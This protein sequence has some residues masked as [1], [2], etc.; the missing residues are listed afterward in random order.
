MPAHKLSQKS[1]V[2]G[3]YDRTAQNQESISGAGVV[4]RGL[5]Y[6]KNVLSSDKGELRK[7]LGTKK[8]VEL[9]AATVLIPYRQPN[10]NDAFLVVT[11]NEDIIGYELVD[12][13]PQ[14]LQTVV[15][16]SVSFPTRSD[17]QG[18]TSSGE[19][20]TYGDWVVTTSIRHYTGD[21]Y[22]YP[23]GQYVSKNLLGT[24]GH[25]CI[26]KDLT[27]GQYI[28][29]ENPINLG[30]L[31]ELKI[32]F[33]T[34]SSSTYSMEYW[35]NLVISYSDDGITW[36]GLNTQMIVGNV[37]TSTR[38]IHYPAALGGDVTMYCSQVTNTVKQTEYDVKHRYWR[39]TF[40]GG[41]LVNNK[42]YEMALFDVDWFNP[43]SVTDFHTTNPYSE[44]D[45][46][47]IKYA[48]DKNKLFIACAGK[49]PILIDSNAGQITATNFTPSN[50]PTLWTLTG[51]YPAAVALSQNRLW[52]GGFENKKT[53]VFASNFG[54]YDTFSENSPL[55]YTDMLNLTCNQLKSGI[56]NIVGGQNV[57]YC[58][59]QDGISMI[60]GGSNG[61]IPTNQSIEFQLRN[62]MPAGDAT[63][64]FKDDIMLY[65]SSDGTKLYGV[66][67]DLLVN[68]F[69]VSDL[70]MYAKDI[71]YNKITELHYVNNESKLVY[72]LTEN[73]K[74]FSLLFEKGNYQGFFPLDFNGEVY[75]ICP[76]KVGRD[77]KLLMVVFRDGR[78]Y[79]EE[80]LDCGH[81]I[82]TST[83][84]LTADEKKWA[85]YDNLENNIALDCYQTYDEGIATLSTV[86][87]NST[88]ATD[89]D[90]S[91]YI[92]KTVMF[93]NTSNKDWDIYTINSVNSLSLWTGN[94]D[95]TGVKYYTL[96]S[97]PVADDDLLDANGNPIQLDDLT[98]SKKI[99][100]AH[101][102][103]DMYGTRI[104]IETRLKA[105]PDTG[106]VSFAYIQT[107]VERY[108]M[109][110]TFEAKRG[111]STSFT[112][113]YPEFTKFQPNLPPTSSIAVISEGRYFDAQTPDSDGYINLPAVCH[114]VIYGVNYEALAIIKIQQPYESL[115]NIAQVDVSVINTT[116]LEIGTDFNDTENIEKIDDSSYYDLTRIT[117]NDTYRQVISDTPEMT[118]NL[119]LRSN[120]GVPFTINAIDV[121][122]NYSNLG[123]D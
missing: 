62:R 9:N 42:A 31:R 21:P 113:A 79:L 109:D 2:N 64:A 52:F 45:I 24:S 20:A 10:E 119:I 38:V 8:L 50:T 97:D 51:G 33:Y 18:V 1:F 110:V 47:K 6:C 43:A 118:K 12:G 101:P 3:Q 58:F 95:G 29:F 91:A 76:I 19:T 108:L 68:R 32:T 115:K 77:Y 26:N 85:T 48:Q 82:D 98:L 83:P 104:T 30:V 17:W 120:K 75:D 35:H 23:A 111:N 69:Q 4:A 39:V 71:T 72:G 70:A 92:D 93:A 46:K 74:M 61:V 99:V 84:R 94:D 90:L 122:M 5:S 107:G 22:A 96:G 49:Q 87:E 88:V 55:Q 60:D 121:Y 114:K 53:T 57:I 73:N 27:E 40:Y 112:M 123:G 36:T 105:L 103:Q 11:P 13:V 80:K 102:V 28:Q 56:T 100:S 106:I 54:D 16:T 116:H 59:S 63:P 34:E 15:G 65:S 86:N 67:F 78:W 37:T 7:R 66:D 44:D 89:V 117:M 14:R 41:N 25:Y 81:Y